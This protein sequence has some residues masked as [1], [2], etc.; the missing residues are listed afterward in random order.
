MKVF[1]YNNYFIK[2]IKIKKKIYVKV[3]ML[4]YTEIVKELENKYIE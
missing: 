1:Y 4:D 3:S 2:K